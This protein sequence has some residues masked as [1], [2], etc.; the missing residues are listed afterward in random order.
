V[1][2][3]FPK[4]RSLEVINRIIIP[5]HLPQWR[6][7]VLLDVNLKKKLITIIDHAEIFEQTLSTSRQLNNLITYLKGTMFTGL[8]QAQFHIHVF[9]IFSHVGLQQME[10]RY[11]VE[12]KMFTSA[13]QQQN[14]YDCGVFVLTSAKRLALGLKL[15]IEDEKGLSIPLRINLKECNAELQRT[16]T[17]NTERARLEI[18]MILNLRQSYALSL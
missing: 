14:G 3:W 1:K 7:W 12:K 16:T 13:Y 10:V 5:W 8:Q 2:T 6:H 9:S 4:D 11:T 17:I 15:G 18:G